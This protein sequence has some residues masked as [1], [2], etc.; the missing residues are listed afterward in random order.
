[1]YKGF[2][3]RQGIDIAWSQIEQDANSLSEDQMHDIVGEMEKG[4]ALEH[5]N[6]IKSY[7]C[8]EDDR[9]HCIN[10]VTEFFTS[11]NLRDYRQRHKHLEVWLMLVPPCVQCHYFY[12][13]C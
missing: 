12:M 7:Q 3:E 11:G 10:F 1:M 8:W 4:I 6:I 13:L 9:H 2:D 5:A